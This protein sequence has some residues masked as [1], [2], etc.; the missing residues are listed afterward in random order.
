MR[1]FLPLSLWPAV[2]TVIP[3]KSSAGIA[4]TL[5]TPRGSSML[6]CRVFKVS[7]GP[8]NDDM[9]GLHLGTGDDQSAI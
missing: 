5:Q 7:D 4:E 9:A 2:I 6:C 3:A 8:T 1:P